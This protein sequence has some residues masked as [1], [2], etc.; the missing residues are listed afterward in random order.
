MSPPSSDKLTC[1]THETCPMKF[2]KVRNVAG[3]K[4]FKNS[5]STRVKAW[6]FMR[7]HVATTE[8]I[9]YPWNLPANTAV[10]HRSWPLGV[11]TEID[12]SY[13]NN[14]GNSTLMMKI[15]PE[16]GQK[17]DV[18]GYSLRWNYAEIM[19][20]TRRPSNPQFTLSET[21]SIPESIRW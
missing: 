1:N 10:S 13:T 16:S 9:H 4:F 18:I 5:C 21:R 8:H 20:E 15:S 11:I 19:V 3:V 17:K 14:L 6:P 12:P 2:N 7:G